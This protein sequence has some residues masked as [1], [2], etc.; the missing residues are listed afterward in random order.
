MKITTNPTL[1]CYWLCLLGNWLLAGLSPIQAQYTAI[2]DASFEHY[3]VQQNIDSDGTVDGRVLTQDIDTIKVLTIVDSVPPTLVIQDL[4]GIEA[5]AALEQLVIRQHHIHTVD[6]SQNTALEEI[7]LDTLQ[8]PFLNL[9]SLTSLEQLRLVGTALDSLLLPT[10][11]SPLQALVLLGCPIRQL[12]LSSYPLLEYVALHEARLTTFSAAQNPLL[13]YLDLVNSPIQHLN[14]SSNIGLEDVRLMGLPVT[15]LNF[16]H[17][18]TLRQLNLQYLPLSS[19]SLLFSSTFL[20]VV[21][22][23]YLD[24][25]FSELS[26]QSS[27][28]RAL[29]VYG[30]AIQT[31]DASSSAVLEHVEIYH[32]PQL[33]SIRFGTDEMWRLNVQHNAPDLHICFVINNPIVILRSWNV[34]ATYDRNCYPNT[35]S[36]QVV[37]DGNNDCLPSQGEQG[38][39]QQAIEFQKTGQLPYVVFT[40]SLGRYTAHLDEGV[41]TTRMLLPNSYRQACIATQMVVV[42][43]VRLFDTLDWTIEEQ[44]SCEDMWVDI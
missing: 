30:T 9:Q 34:D 5:F 40:D 4:T 7:D 23:K 14:L 1:L 37:L 10:A 26:L 22:I 32:N 20:E 15:H 19:D 43:K 13:K 6:L 28:L 8:V 18:D 12:D 21:Q 42:D 27:E 41:Y 3:L 2:P 25:S 11:N 31:L 39:R 38:I 33:Y 35:I 36:G 29:H 17:C 24:P 16:S 44:S